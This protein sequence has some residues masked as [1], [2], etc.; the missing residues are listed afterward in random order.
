[1][2]DKTDAIAELDTARDNFRGRIADLPDE[3]YGE[4]WLGTWNLSEV[5]AHM[6]GW[7]REMSGGFGRVANGER[8]APAGVDYSNPDP[9]NAKF[10][11]VAKPGKAALADWDEAYGQYRSAAESLD[12]SFYGVDP[13]KGRP[14]IGNRLLHGA[15]I[16]HFA[17]HQ[18]DVDAWLASRK[19]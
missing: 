9:W 5:L 16:D 7:Y 15:G 11:A 8:P 19:G 6:S 13:E 10:A 14:R 18:G 17:E 3:A 12:D 2:S 1:M 4:V